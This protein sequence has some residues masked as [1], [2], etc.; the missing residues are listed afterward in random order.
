MAS[1][2]DNMSDAEVL[3]TYYD[4]SRDPNSSSTTL[5]Y[6]SSSEVETGSHNSSRSS[7]STSGLESRS[8][9]SSVFSNNSNDSGSSSV[10][11][12]DVRDVLTSKY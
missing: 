7:T 8:S 2:P 11:S 6:I 1:N 4:Y 10:C 5:P 3:E 9:I 12:Q